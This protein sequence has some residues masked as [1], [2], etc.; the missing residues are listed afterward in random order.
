[1]IGA[2]D[3]TAG[4]GA[5]RRSEVVEGLVEDVECASEEVLSLGVDVF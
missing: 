3:D 2:W 4:A 1:M 5:V